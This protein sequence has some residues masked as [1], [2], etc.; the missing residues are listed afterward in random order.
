MPI[1]YSKYPDDWEEIRQAIL[2]R[3]ENKCELCGAENHKP[4]WKT[5]SIVV[6]TIHH[7]DRDKTNNSEINLIALCQRCHLRL[8]LE[9]HINK[10]KERKRMLTNKEYKN[11]LDIPISFN[12]EL[13]KEM[14]KEVIRN[15]KDFLKRNDVKNTEINIDIKTEIEP[16]K[17]YTIKILTTIYRKREEE[18]KMKMG[19]IY[20]GADD[21]KKYLE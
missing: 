7:I 4:H 20:H 15:I 6:L 1:D 11:Q 5:G 14:G 17:P 8:D 12:D 21:V 10:R 18:I 16:G 13:I 3:A 19:G 9:I 2:A